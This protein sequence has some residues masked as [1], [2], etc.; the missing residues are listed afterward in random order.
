MSRKHKILGKSCGYRCTQE[1]TTIINTEEIIQQFILFYCVDL[2]L[3]RSVLLIFFSL[4]HLRINLSPLCLN[5]HHK[6]LIFNDSHIYG[7]PIL[8]YFRSTSLNSIKKDQSIY[9]G[10]ETVKLDLLQTVSIQDQNVQ[11]DPYPTLSDKETSCN[12]AIA[13]LRL[14]TTG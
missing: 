4:E 11:S 14:F 12:F 13:I 9:I 1:L 10:K 6:I 7:V 8:T 2:D 3:H 5:L